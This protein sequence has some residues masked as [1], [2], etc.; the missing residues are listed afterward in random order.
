MR[1]WIGEVLLVLGLVTAARLGSAEVTFIP[2]EEGFTIS[3][4]GETVRGAQGW[5]RV[6]CVTCVESLRVNSLLVTYTS[7]RD[8][9]GYAVVGGEV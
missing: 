8:L 9:F 2:T 3:F 7:L 1:Q 5:T 6:A 4:Q